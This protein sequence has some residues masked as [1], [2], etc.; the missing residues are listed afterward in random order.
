MEKENDATV[1]SLPPSFS[2]SLSLS[3]SPCARRVRRGNEVENRTLGGT[4]T[5]P[6]LYVFEDT[7]RGFHR[8]HR[9]LILQ[10]RVEWRGERVLEAVGRE[11]IVPR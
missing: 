9:S 10:T 6:F 2:L 1:V 8:R 11:E 3:L 7:S 5:P 4:S